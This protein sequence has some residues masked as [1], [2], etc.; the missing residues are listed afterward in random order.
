MPESETTAEIKQKTV[1]G[2]AWRLTERICAQVVTF[3]VTVVLARILTPEDYGIVAIVNVFVAVFDVLVSGG[4]S[5]ALIQKKNA[6][7][8]DF[9]TIFYANFVMSA[10]LYVLLFFVSPLVARIYKNNLLTPVL[11][12]MGIKLFV[13]AINSVQ[14]VY[15]ARRMI[16]KKFFFATLLGTV[17]SATVGIYMA[18]KGFGVWALVMQIITNPFIDTIVLFITV[19]WHPRWMFNKESLKSLFGYGW[20][21]TSTSFSGILFGKLK[22][23][24]VGAK[25]TA[26]DLAYYNRGESLPVLITS[27]IT[28]T[29]ESVLF[30][31][32]SKFQ[33]DK[34]K[35]KS[36]VRRSMSLGSYV[37]MPLLFGLAAVSDKITLILFTEKW[38]S[39]VPFVQIVCFQELT[40]LLN[41]VNLQAIKAVR[42]ADILLKLE[43]IKKP[44]YLLIIILC[45]QISPLF[46]AIGATVYGLIALIINS[47]PNKHLLDYSFLEQLNDAK[48]SFFM[49]VVM[50]AVVF[51]VGKIK[52]NMFLVLVVQIAVGFFLYTLMSVLFKNTNFYY[53]KTLFKDRR[54]CDTRR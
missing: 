6:D 30:P 3:S 38:A 2:F 13:S 5:S 16:F 15:V 27:N 46:M 28:T 37:L 48:D 54:F 18:L 44:I 4:L 32:I 39:S 17:C 53:L 23:L 29:L 24:I 41:S 8:T 43:F 26:S 45:V 52:I 25:Y 19:D 21:V 50:G 11:R 36:A 42:R 7:E 9:S 1:S 51:A 34:L 31:A 49:S 12:V 14:Q 20:K 33:D 22:N 35:L 10:I 40:E 47:F